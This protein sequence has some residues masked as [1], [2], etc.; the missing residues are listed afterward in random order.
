MEIGDRKGEAISYG[1]LGTVFLSLGE[2]VKA[3]EYHEKALAIGIETGNR[4]TE[5]LVRRGLSDMFYDLGEYVQAEECFKKA[6]ETRIRM[7]DSSKENETDDDLSSG[8]IS[9]S[10]TKYGDAVR[11]YEKALAINI[12]IGRR[13]GEALCYIRLAR[14]CVEIH[15]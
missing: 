6:S 13:R 8:E 7:E 15:W 12:R 5:M 1:N 10:L 11:C 2:Y 3:K 14:N 9:L 4:A